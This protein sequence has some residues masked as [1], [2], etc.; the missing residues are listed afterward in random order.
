MRQ[1]T[2]PGFD[3]VAAPAAPAAVAWRHLDDLDAARQAIAALRGPVG[4]DLETSGL[5]PVTDTARLLSLCDGE[6]PVLV[7]DLPRVGGLGALAGALRDR[8]AVAH[9]ATFDMG[10]LAAA[11]APLDLHCSLLAW[12]ALT[13]RR[14]SLARLAQELLG[15]TLDKTLQVSDWQGSLDAAQLQYAATDAWCVRQLFPLLAER[16]RATRRTGLYRL[17]RQAQSAVVAMQ[18]A[19]IGFDRAAFDAL[20]ADMG[21]RRDALARD[22]A[23]A[24][25]GINPA[26]AQQL[27]QWIAREAGGADCAA[28]A[29]WPRTAGGQLRTGADD[30]V[31]N[32]DRLP[33]ATR[34]VVSQRLLPFRDLDKR[35]S[36]FGDGLLGQINPGTGRLHPRYSLA[37]TNTGRMSCSEPNL[38]QIPRERAY[39]ALFVAPPGRRLVIADYSQIELR[40]AAHLAPEPRLLEAYAQGMDTHRLTGA[41]I[42]DKA[43]EAVTAAERQLAKAVNFGLLFGQGVRGLQA[44]AA[45][46]YGVQL[47]RAQ[48]QRYREAWFDAYPGFRRWHRESAQA[49]Q[50]SL[51]V[52]TRAGRVHTW[53]DAASISLPS[54]Y[55][56]P[57]QG[58]AAEVLLA[59]LHALQA[60]LQGLDARPV[61]AVHDEIIVECA[62]GDAAATCEA[63]ARA[64]RAGMAAL[65]PDASLDG[66]VE[67]RA[68]AS[69]AD[70]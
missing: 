70:K 2:L 57:V 31:R 7:I 3:D 29:D 14:A 20:L 56:F 34:E 63:L 54:V 30:L 44:Y 16:L 53:P 18:L 6:A 51:R 50:R 12:H 67:A 8:V 59:A 17:Q 61:A 26:S 21:R 35:L 28:L 49:A 4:L 43:P 33:P 69:W 55:N 62:E 45:A 58:S 42:L 19:G 5:D 47:D 1:A 66:L 32:L 41:M 37:G 11:G 60:T 40:V 15:L 48:A 39:R 52:A 24:L 10:F 22:L 13:N 25:G 46:S 64:M 36:A 27:G 23:E 38:H 9:N 68:G 65:F